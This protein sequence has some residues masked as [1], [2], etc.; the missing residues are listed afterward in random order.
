MAYT[1]LIEEAKDLN[2]SNIIEVIDFIRFLK[3]KQDHQTHNRQSNTLKRKLKYMADDFNET[4]ECFKE[5][6]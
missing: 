1:D 5:Y 2:D 3:T 6:M 4:P